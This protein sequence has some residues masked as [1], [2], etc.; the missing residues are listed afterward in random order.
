MAGAVL[1]VAGTQITTSDLHLLYAR[2]FA[3]LGWR[4][5]FVAHDSHLPFAEKV[6]QQSRLRNSAA[7]FALVNA[8]VRRAAAR[9][10]PDL[11]VISG[12]NWFLTA[13]TVR[14]LRRRGAARVVL[15]EH[16]LQVFRP[17]QASALREFDHVFVQDSGLVDLLRHAS[18]VRGV[19]LLGAACD[20]REHRPLELSDGEVAQY[21][22][23]VS[24]LGYA[25][26]N[27]LELFEQLTG[28]NLRLWGLNWDASPTLQPF[29]DRRPVFGLQ[30]TRIYNATRVNINLQS[31]SYQLDGVTCRPFEVAACGGFCLCDERRDLARFFR[32]GQ[33]VVAFRDATDLKRQID[34]YLRHPD[35]ARAIAAA[36]RTRVLAEHTYVHRVQQMLATLGLD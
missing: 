28:Y 11:V 18:P 7:H 30:K 10:R 24:Y 36:A 5:S 1:I 8:R 34:Y 21:G 15:N 33:E 35:E 19:S 13:A 9:A 22:A 23:D 4:V 20:P 31:V 29:F 27:R 14:Y 6:L 3:D 17:Y 16:H 26:G 2:A 12:S 32:P 25:Y